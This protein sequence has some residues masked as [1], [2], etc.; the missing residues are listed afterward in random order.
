MWCSK[1]LWQNMKLY[2]ALIFLIG[3]YLWAKGQGEG[4]QGKQRYNLRCSGRVLHF[5]LEK[6]YFFCPEKVGYICILSLIIS[7]SLTFN[8]AYKSRGQASPV[9]YTLIRTTHRV[10]LQIPALRA[11]QWNRYTKL[12][13]IPGKFHASYIISFVHRMC[14]ALQFALPVSSTMQTETQ[15]VWYVPFQH[16]EDYYWLKYTIAGAKSLLS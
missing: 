14:F 5:P 12:C 1:W 7:I 13:H 10:W 6:H 9:R 2:C 4:S 11:V 15:W 16:T 8:S 3:T